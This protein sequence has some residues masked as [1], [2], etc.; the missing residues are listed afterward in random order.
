MFDGKYHGHLDEA[1]VEFDETGLLV[2]EERGVPEDTVDG[3]V[4]VPFNDPAALA[5][6]LEA[7]T[8]PS[9]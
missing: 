4:L 6:A 5:R 7:A 8:S 3:T 1:L 9:C 2:I